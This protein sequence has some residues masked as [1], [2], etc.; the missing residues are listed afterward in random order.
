[1]CQLKWASGRSGMARRCVRLAKTRL[2]SEALLETWVAA[3]S[4]LLGK[5]LLII[6]RQVMTAHRTFID[7]LAVDAEGRVHTIELKR[8]QTAR[9]VVAQALDYASWVVTLE[10]EDLNDI[11]QKYT[12]TDLA[13][14]FQSRFGIAFQ[15][16]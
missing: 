6:G 7:L 8:D 5:K 1:M 16:R 9:D 13:T 4:D 10:S 3:E 11:C 14:A 12:K 15:K 2:E